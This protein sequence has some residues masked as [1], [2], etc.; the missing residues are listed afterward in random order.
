MLVTGKNMRIWRFEFFINHNRALADCFY[1]NLTD[2]RNPY[3]CNFAG[4]CTNNALSETN[5]FLDNQ[6]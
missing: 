1:V 3:F 6:R 4:V 2:A 5:Y